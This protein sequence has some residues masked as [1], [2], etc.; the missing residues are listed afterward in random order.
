MLGQGGQPGDRVLLCFVDHL[1]KL[2]EHFGAY[3]GEVVTPFPTKPIT[4]SKPGSSCGHPT[5]ECCVL[6]AP[7]QWASSLIP[8][9]RRAAWAGAVAKSPTRRHR[10]RPCRHDEDPQQAGGH[11]PMPAI[12]DHAVTGLGVGAGLRRVAGAMRGA[13]TVALNL[14]SSGSTRARVAVR[15]RPRARR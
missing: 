12:P 11:A 8:A 15:A 2:L 3:A 6:A 1:P 10:F 4:A 7:A 5:S 13:T 9:P 14:V